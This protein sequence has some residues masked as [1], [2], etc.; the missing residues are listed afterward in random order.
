[1]TSESKKDIKIAGES[2]TFKKLC[3]SQAKGDFLALKSRGRA[4]IMIHMKTNDTEKELSRIEKELENLLGN[5][6]EEEVMPK[7]AVK[8]N[9]KQVVDNG[10]V[11][12]DYPKHGET[13]TSR[14][15][16]VR[17]G[18]ID[19]KGVE[20]SIDNG[21][22]QPA[23]SSVGYWWH[24]WNNIT[25]GTHELIAKMHRNDGSFL[26]SKRRRCKIV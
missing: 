22:W 20:I 18:A 15:Y 9:T 21:P 6:L 13:I 4:V 17:I 25:P 24:D 23:R 14:H 5:S 11:V 12:I 16:T 8:K 7:T 1:L 26:I 2:Y 19:A 10:Y 3:I